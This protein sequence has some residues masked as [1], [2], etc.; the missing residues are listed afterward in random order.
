VSRNA[1]LGDDAQPPPG[2]HASQQ[3]GTPTATHDVPPFGGVQW[4]ALD[5]VEHFVTPLLVRQQVT[6]PVLPQVDLAAHFT[7]APWQLGFVSCK[8][9][10]AALVAQLTYWPWF[11]KLSQGHAASTAARAAATLPISAPVT[12]HLAALWSAVSPSSESAMTVTK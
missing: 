1:P 10:F 12:S 8:A 4:L 7:T 6:N 11:M 5:F 3:L 2:K 9:V